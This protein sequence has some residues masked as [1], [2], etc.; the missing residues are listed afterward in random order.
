[1]HGTVR[2]VPVFGSDGSSG[3]R[4]SR[5]LSSVL[6]ERHGSGSDFGSRKTVP[7]VPVP[8][9]M[10]FLQKRFRFP[11]PVRFLGHPEKMRRGVQSTLGAIPF[12]ALLAWFCLN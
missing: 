7:A 6:A 11:V 4:V 10:V 3:E 1:M 12:P 5:Y 9:T 2:A 8:L